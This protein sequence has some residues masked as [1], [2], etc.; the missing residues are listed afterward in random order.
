MFFPSQGALQ[1]LGTAVRPGGLYHQTQERGVGAWPRSL[2]QEV[3]SV[4][5]LT[6]ARLD[7]LGQ[8]TSSPS[9]VRCGQKRQG[10]IQFLK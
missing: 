7:D 10:L 9:C 2:S 8:V 4:P 3:W 6:V 5:T 1:C